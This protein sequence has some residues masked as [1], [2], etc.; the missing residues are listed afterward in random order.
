MEKIQPA[1]FGKPTQSRHPLPPVKSPPARS[2]HTFVAGSQFTMTIAGHVVGAGSRLRLDGEHKLPDLRN[3]R[4]RP[5]VGVSAEPVFLVL[6]G[7]SAGRSHAVFLTK[8]K[9]YSFQ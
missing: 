3:A 1:Q 9:R 6:Q 5:N 7:Q 4:G 8:V 2:M